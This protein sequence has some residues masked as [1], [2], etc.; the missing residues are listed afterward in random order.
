MDDIRL[1]PN[2]LRKLIAAGECPFVPTVPPVGDAGWIGD[3]V[4]ASG[5]A[6]HAGEDAFA[7]ACA[8]G[9]PLPQKACPMCF[10]GDFNDIRVFGIF[11]ADDK[12]GIMPKAAESCEEI[13]GGA[14][15]AAA[16]VSGVDL[17]Y[18][19]F[20]MHNSTRFNGTTGTSVTDGTKR[21]VAYVPFV[22]YVPANS[23]M[24][25]R[26][27]DKRFQGGVDVFG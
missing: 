14:F 13:P 25:R 5:E 27:L 16:L 18:F 19:Q 11:A 26:W 2:D 20:V 23:L 17:D 10:A 6:T 4:E 1:F 9:K 21:T 15:G 12:S 3:A 8:V 7:G 22:T 24:L